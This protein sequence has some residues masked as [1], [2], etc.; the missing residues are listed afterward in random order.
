MYRHPKP[1]ARASPAEH[2]R[3]LEMKCSNWVVDADELEGRIK[4]L[5]LG[6]RA[7]PEFEGLLRARLS[8]S[9]SGRE[10]AQLVY[11]ASTSG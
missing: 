5:I 3:Y 4:D 6:Q 8:E 1:K 10:T 9:D 7:S 2:T 11:G